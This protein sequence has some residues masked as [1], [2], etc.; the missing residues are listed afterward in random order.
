MQINP[1]DLNENLL[2]FLNQLS[3]L[4]TLTDLDS[5]FLMV[6]QATAKL[7]NVP[8]DEAIELSYDKM[9]CAA[10]KRAAY[11]QKQDE[12]V[13]QQRKELKILSLQSSGD[14]GELVLSFGIKKPLFNMA[15]EIIGTIGEFIDISNLLSPRLFSNCI[16][17]ECLYGKKVQ[18]FE[19]S[20]DN[21]YRDLGLSKKQ[22]EVFF[23]LLRSKSTKEIAH[24]LELSP[25]TIESYIDNIKNKL[26]CNNK[27]QLVEKGIV[28]GY[29]GFLPET[30]YAKLEWV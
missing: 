3:N 19:V 26:G 9:K 22:S 29:L 27:N 12:R 2:A 8:V 20:I 4:I 18:Q 16:I 14:T 1:F 17:F 30:L 10:V 11:Y 24:I 13:I 5:N 28:S 7:I 21:V 6:N 25:R 15:G 23:F